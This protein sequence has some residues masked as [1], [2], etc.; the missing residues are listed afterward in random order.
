MQLLL[1]NPQ[2]PDRVLL[3][4]PFW[5]GRAFKKDLFLLFLSLIFDAAP[6]GGNSAGPH[7]KEIP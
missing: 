1:V 5:T 7:G 3:P 6:R 2:G 4:V